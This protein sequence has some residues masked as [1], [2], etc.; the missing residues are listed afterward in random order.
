MCDMTFHDIADLDVDLSDLERGHTSAVDEC[1]E[2]LN[3][4]DAEVWQ[5]VASSE[6]ESQAHMN[7]SQSLHSDDH[8]LDLTKLPS[9]EVSGD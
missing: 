4:N 2:R 8:P 7:A 6:V 5:V 3:L 1:I 9:A